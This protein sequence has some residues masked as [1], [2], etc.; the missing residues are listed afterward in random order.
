MQIAPGLVNLQ[1]VLQ[2]VYVSHIVCAQRIHVN[3]HT[4]VVRHT[5][6]Y[7]IGVSWARVDVCRLVGEPSVYSGCEYHLVL[8]LQESMKIAVPWG[9]MDVQQYPGEYVCGEVSHVFKWLQ[10]GGQAGGLK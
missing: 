8:V 9:A 2:D 1:Y 7:L 5:C 10:W 6:M 3:R 4:Y